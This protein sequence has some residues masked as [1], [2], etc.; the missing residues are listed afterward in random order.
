[1]V[2]GTGSLRPKALTKARSGRRWHDEYAAART[3]LMAAL[4]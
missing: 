2:S 1:L 4:A 3:E